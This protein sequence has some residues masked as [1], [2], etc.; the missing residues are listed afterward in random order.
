MINVVCWISTFWTL[1]TVSVVRQYKANRIASKHKL[2][3]NRRVSCFIKQQQNK[4]RFSRSVCMRECVWWWDADMC[5]VRCWC[6]GIVAFC[7]DYNH[8]DVFFS[9]TFRREMNSFRFDTEN[10]KCV[11]KCIHFAVVYVS[12]IKMPFTHRCITN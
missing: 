12:A 6:A 5:L 3:P 1:R 8:R 10:F 7:A 2:N 4:S 9:C 11:R